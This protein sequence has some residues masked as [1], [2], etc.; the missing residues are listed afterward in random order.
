MFLIVKL[1]CFLYTCKYNQS[2]RNKK[3]N[4]YINRFNKVKKLRWVLFYKI[5]K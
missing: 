5:K 4:F 3:I 2:Y 1:V